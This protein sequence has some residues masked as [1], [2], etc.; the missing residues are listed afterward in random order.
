VI[1]DYKFQY[2]LEVVARLQSIY[3]LEWHRKVNGV[4]IYDDKFV[5]RLYPDSGNIVNT[6]FHYSGPIN[7]TNTIPNMLQDQA[8][9]VVSKNIGTVIED[10]GLQI[11]GD[12]LYYTFKVEGGNKVRVDAKTG[13][14]ETY[15]FV[16]GN[17]VGK[18]AVFDP[19][20]YFVERQLVWAIVTLIIFAGGLAYY[21]KSLFLPK[22]K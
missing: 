1:A 19:V 10:T 14:T 7:I 11:Q 5:V 13:Y 12:K 3:Y 6:E 18:S 17:T 22:R 4:L 21:K 8:N 16:Q 20:Q 15:D 9:F 2:S